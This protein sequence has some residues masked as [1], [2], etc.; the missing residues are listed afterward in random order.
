MKIQEYN[1]NIYKNINKHS[2]K[3]IIR[4]HTN[5]VKWYLQWASILHHNKVK[6][7]QNE[8]LVNKFTVLS[9]QQLVDDT[10]EIRHLRGSRDGERN[11]I[12][13][14]PTEKSTLHPIQTQ[15]TIFIIWTL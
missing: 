9:F 12:Y 6:T 7:R 10:T 8:W 14:I 15:P 1:K 13:Q 11:I 5:Y 4:F 3:V 2:I